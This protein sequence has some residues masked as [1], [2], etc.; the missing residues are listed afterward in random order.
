MLGGIVVAPAIGV[1]M[2]ATSRSFEWSPVFLR[3]A[4]AGVTLYGAALLFV[5][6]SGLVSGLMSGRIPDAL[7]FNSMAATWAA[8]TWT[9]LF[10]VLWPL[11]YFNHSLISKAWARRTAVKDGAIAG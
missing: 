7:F 3:V 2:G 6:A 8:L 10:V 1:L 5:L 11:A 9:G 4:I